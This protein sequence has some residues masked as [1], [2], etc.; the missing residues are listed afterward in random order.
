[1]QAKQAILTVS[2]LLLAASGADA[3]TLRDTKG[4]AEMPPASYAG[5][6]YIDSNGC[7]FIRTGY[8]GNSIWVP[9][10]S[11]SRVVL[12]GQTPTFAAGTSQ[13]AAPQPAAAQPAPMVSV[14]SNVEAA[15]VQPSR[16]KFN[17]Q[18]RKSVV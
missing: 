9:R 15:P 14:A 16:P 1:M 10:V 11:H 18:D 8:G 6:Q 3:R 7:V 17:W 2:V 13:P 5:S 12:C 4:P